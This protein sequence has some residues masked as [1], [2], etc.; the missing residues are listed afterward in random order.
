M[1]TL[2]LQL[3]GTTIL[4]FL[5]LNKNVLYINKTKIEDIYIVLTHYYI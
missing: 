4:I 2:N 5:M 3:G 1:S